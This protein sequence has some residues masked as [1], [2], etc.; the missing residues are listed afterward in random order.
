MVHVDFSN[1]RIDRLIEAFDCRHL[2]RVGHTVQQVA[3]VELPCRRYGN[4]SRGNLVLLIELVNGICG[5]R[6]CR[7]VQQLRAF[8]KPVICQVHVPDTIAA[9]GNNTVAQRF[10][11]QFPHRQS[12]SQPG[13][14][15]FQ[16]RSRCVPAA[17]LRGHTEGNQPA[18]T[19]QQQNR[20]EQSAG[21]SPCNVCLL[22]HSLFFP[23]ADLFDFQEHAPPLEQQLHGHCTAG[24]YQKGGVC[25]QKQQRSKQRQRC[26]QQAEPELFLCPPQQVPP[27]SGHAVDCGQKN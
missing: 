20:P 26:P 3:R 7:R 10:Q 5:S 11:K 13:I 6:H 21:K 9:G 23:A 22:R 27:I 17:G 14:C 16:K 15:L 2:R 19:A 25:C 4:H 8:Q 24:L 1:G 18:D 12:R